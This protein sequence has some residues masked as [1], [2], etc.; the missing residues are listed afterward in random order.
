MTSPHFR[1]RSAGPFVATALLAVVC[2]GVASAQSLGEL[3]RKEEER[4]KA[5]K[6]PGKLYTNESLRPEA[7]GAATGTPSAATPA[8]ASG[9]PATPPS[10]SGTQP[11]P[12][13]Q[14]PPA[15][16]ES[17]EA[18]KDEAYWRQRMQTARDTLQRARMFADALQS[19]INALSTDFAARDDPAQ[20][21]VIGT[22]R[23]K[24]LAELD[25]VK[26]EID[27]HTKTIASIQDEARR[28]GVPPGWLR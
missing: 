27:Q 10:P 13:A 6:T 22:D 17:P 21:D 14:A 5:I 28:A 23:Q 15:E 25:R 3:A 19:R 18:G 9:T 12:P 16:A 24:A 2:V 4:R 11:T 20:R 8:S 7:G 26:Q 1:L